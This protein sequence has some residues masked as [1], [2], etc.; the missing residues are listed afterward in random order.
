MYRALTR[1]KYQK[2][3]EP[4]KEKLLKLEATNAACG[5]QGLLTE[6]ECDILRV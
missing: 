4:L 1:A 3:V 5:E 6:R 2:Q